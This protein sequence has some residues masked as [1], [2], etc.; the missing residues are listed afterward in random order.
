VAQI[1]QES[2]NNPDPGYVPPFERQRRQTLGQEVGE[3][4]L[5][6]VEPPVEL[7]IEPAK[8]TKA[9]VVWRLDAPL[10]TGSDQ[11]FGDVLPAP[12]N[13]CPDELIMEKDEV[14]NLWEAVNALPP[15]DRE[16]I[17]LHHGLRDGIALTQKKVATQ[18]GLSEG[19]THL[20]HKALLKQ[21]R[22]NE[23]LTAN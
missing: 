9:P 18:I 8:A 17:I 12:P 13:T 21:L 15:R 23:K 16:L 1:P 7:P 11:V 10:Y 22:K 5:A 4:A 19:Y 6:P 20:R 14:A 3:T 2:S